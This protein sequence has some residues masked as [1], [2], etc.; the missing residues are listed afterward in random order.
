MPSVTTHHSYGSRVGNSLKNIFRG[1]VLVLLSIALIVWNE[2]NYV[3]QKRALKEWAEIVQEATID[4]INPELDQ[5]EIHV[6]GEATSN[7][8]AL[9]DTTFGVTADDLKLKRTVEMYQWYEE[10]S[11]S[12]TDNYGW[13]EDCTTTYDYHKKWSDE[14]I[15][16]SSF[17]ETAWH[18]NPSS[19][20]F[21]SAERAKSPITLWVYTLT[22]VFTQQLTNYKTINLSE[23]NIN[24]PEKYKLIAD[25]TTTQTD[26]TTVEDN[27]NSYLYGDSE[28]TTTE[29]TTTETTNNNTPNE[30]FQ[31]NGDYIYI[32]KNPNE[33][34]IWDLRITFSSVKPGTVSVVWKQSGNEISNYTTSND[35]TIALLDEGNVSAADMFLA[36]QKA[37]RN[38]TWVL[39]LLW[40]FLMFCWFSM[41][42][43]FLETLAKVL[44]FLSNLIGVWTNIIALCL[45]IVIGFIA[46]GIAWIAVRPIVWITCLIVAAIWIFFL[47]K[48]RKNKKDTPIEE[49]PE[50]IKEPKE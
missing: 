21:T 18:E 40:L 47:I 24:I 30:K 1:I 22:P 27:N 37:N 44:P 16:S 49:K 7:A 35:R 2:N 29:S 3:Q 48:S 39:R 28:N 6:S 17:Y 9:Q 20:E 33:P 25:Q 14:P 32:W 10:S 43:Q 42:F 4:Q 38:L 11:E 34:A 36:A 26:T 41:M 23:Q 12:C 19:W 8:E 46:I 31:I 50:P 45:T 15:S 13:S 5:K